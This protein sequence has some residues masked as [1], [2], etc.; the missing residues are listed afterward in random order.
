MDTVGAETV[1]EVLGEVSFP[2]EKWQIT[3]CADILGADLRTR[4]A[5]YSLPVQLYHSAAEV[6]AALDAV[7]G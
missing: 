5:L 1:T 3:T 4:R 7:S 6:T 2:A